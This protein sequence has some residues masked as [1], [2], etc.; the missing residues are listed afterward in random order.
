MLYNLLIAVQ[1]SVYFKVGF[2]IFFDYH[3][4]TYFKG[5][6][7]FLKVVMLDPAE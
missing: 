2:I 4:A 1:H 7:T 5:I 6:G 3:L